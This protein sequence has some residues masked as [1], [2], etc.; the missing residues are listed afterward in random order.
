M[1]CCSPPPR[2]EA[3]QEAVW[4]GLKDGTFQ[5]FSSDH[6]PYRFDET[7][8][9]PKGDE[10]TFKEMANGVPGLEVRLPLLFSE[11]VRKGRIT[12]NEFVALTATNHARIYGLSSAQGHDRGRLR[13]RPRDLG[14]RHRV[15]LDAAM[16]HDNV[17][18]TPYEGRQ[19]KGW[20]VTVLTRGGWWW[21]KRARQA[22]GG[23]RPGRFIA[24]TR[25]DASLPAGRQIPEMAQLAVW[26]TPLA[27]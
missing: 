20:P 25:T 11:G 23:A 24:R 16:L 1:W 9:M 4:A 17:G 12:L 10:T 27:P 21:T 8:K 6:A 22:Q 3:A 2:D 19:L 15:T 5:I 14:S 13:R 18:Y 7:G 26:N